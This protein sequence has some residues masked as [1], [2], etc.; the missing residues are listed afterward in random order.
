MS[1]TGNTP[2]EELKDRILA[3]IDDL[4]RDPVVHTWTYKLDEAA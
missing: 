1:L 3:A 2:C 4:N